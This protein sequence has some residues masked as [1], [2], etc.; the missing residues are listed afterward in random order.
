VYISSEEELA[1]P[2]LPS[3]LS[4]V[5]R[6]PFVTLRYVESAEVP[7]DNFQPESSVTKNPIASKTA[8]VG[9]SVIFVRKQGERR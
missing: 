2:F 7:E 6:I 4:E 5:L 3:T 1:R 8:A 9:N